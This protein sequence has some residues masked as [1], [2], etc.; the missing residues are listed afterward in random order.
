MGLKKEEG[1][2]KVCKNLFPFPYLHQP[3]LYTANRHNP[4]AAHFT[5]PQAKLCRIHVLKNGNC[6]ENTRMYMATGTLE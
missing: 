1:E 2:L 5:P 3:S 6:A 4:M